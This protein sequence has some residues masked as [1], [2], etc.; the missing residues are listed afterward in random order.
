MGSQNQLLGT[1]LT[2]M[3]VIIGTGFEMFVNFL[4]FAFKVNFNKDKLVC[5]NAVI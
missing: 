3:P 5:T 1:R 2:R 4:M